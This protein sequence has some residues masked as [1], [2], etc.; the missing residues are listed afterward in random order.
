M[1]IYETILLAARYLDEDLIKQ[2]QEDPDF[3]IDT[4]RNDATPLYDIIQ[5]M[6][7][8]SINFLIEHGA[9]INWV[10]EY[11]TPLIEAVQTNNAQIVKLLIKKGADVN[12]TIES[13]T[14]LLIACDRSS[15]AIVKLLVE[16]GADINAF[17]TNNDFP[18]PFSNAISYGTA[19]IVQYLIDEGANLNGIGNNNAVISAINARRDDILDLIL[20]AGGNAN[21]LDSYEN[22]CLGMSIFDSRI[23]TAEILLKHKAD[24]NTVTAEGGLL[25]LQHVSMWGN[26]KFAELLLTFNADIHAPDH[27]GWTALMHADFHYAKRVTDL[28]KNAGAYLPNDAQ[29]QSIANINHGHVDNL[30]ETIAPLTN[31]SEF[32]KIKAIEAAIRSSAP[33]N[34][35]TAL[36]NIGCPADQVTQ[37]NEYLIDIAIKTHNLEIAD[38][39]MKENV[40]MLQ[41]GYP[42]NVSPLLVAAESEHVD[43]VQTILAYLTLPSDQDILNDAANIA[44]TSNNLEMLNIL[45]EAGA[46]IDSTNI[47]S[48]GFGYSNSLENTITDGHHDMLRYLIT[49]GVNLDEEIGFMNLKPLHVAINAGD[50]ITVQILVEEGH[51][52]INTLSGISQNTTPLSLATESNH[53]DI[54]QYLLEKG[55]STKEQNHG[56]FFYSPLVISAITQGNLEILKSLL[57]YGA[58]LALTDNS[59]NTPLHIAVLEN[60][61][62]MI[63]AL[64][65]AGASLDAINLD[66]QTPLELAQAIA[67]KDAI[68]I[69]KNL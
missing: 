10:S 46:S 56:G 12:A 15:I 50:L 60:Q 7:A 44:T 38:L 14:P 4:Q 54:V 51:A 35:V 34:L 11:S 43:M 24:A 67:D 68:Q 36:L 66:S 41:P 37:K 69:L 49:Q 47:N 29:W 59:Q 55:A 18:S 40:P 20:N 25:P 28:L 3:D 32:I 1:N 64:V 65:E 16:A 33:I 2:L 42:F 45:T 5:D 22:T 6:R 58:E 13:S 30:K 19:E 53:L 48:H 63:K 62:E 27:F 57:S 23:C 39:L 31:A 52:D 17:A 26:Y 61:I 9:N 8:D 21:A